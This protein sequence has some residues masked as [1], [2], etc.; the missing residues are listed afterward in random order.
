LLFTCDTII[1]HS[2]KNKKENTERQKRKNKEENRKKRKR[3]GESEP[4]KE[5]GEEENMKD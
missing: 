4:K 2:L 3:G 5:N 1:R